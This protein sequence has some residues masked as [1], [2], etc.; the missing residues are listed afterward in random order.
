VD[1]TLVNR[2]GRELA[3]PS[4]FDDFSEAAHARRLRDAM[5]RRG[6]VVF[7]TEWWHFDWKD[8]TSFPPLR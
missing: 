5:E 2:T 8:W 1:V 6:F 7:P 4:D 3:M